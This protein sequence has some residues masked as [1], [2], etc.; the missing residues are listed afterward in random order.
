MKDLTIIILGNKKVDIN[1][2]VE[3]IY[4][5][6]FNIQKDVEKSQGRNIVFIKPEDKLSEYYFNEILEKAQGTYDCCF[7]NYKMEYDYKN[8]LKINTNESELKERKPYYGDY[9]WSFMFNKEKLLKVLQ[10]DNSVEFNQEVDKLF[11]RT[12]A[13]KKVIY[14]HNPKSERIVYKTQYTDIKKEEYYKNII[15]IGEGANGTFNGYISW[16]KNIGRC[17]GNIYD[18]TILY[19]KISEVTFKAFSKYFKCVQRSNNVNYICDRLLVTYSTYFYPQNIIY[20]DQNYMFIHGNMSDYSNSRRYYD[21]IYTHYIAVS[22]IAAKKA[23][24]YFPTKNI[25]H[26]INPF[27]LDEEL[28]KPHLKLTSALRFSHVK[29]PERIEIFAKVL[30]ELNIPYTW[31]VFTDSKENTN[32]NGVIYRKRTPN[33]LPYIKDSDYF[34][35]LSDSE[36]MPYCILEALAVNT[37]VIVTP[38]EAYEEIGVKNKENGY[39]IPFDYFK[40]EYKEE[41]IKVV[42]EIYREKD[43]EVN[44]TIDEK[45]WDGYNNIFVK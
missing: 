30:D 4:S 13:I 1:K 32:I 33:P 34:V 38:L 14:F 27:K 17:F 25:E 31:N 39:I 24:G 26:I 10:I 29:R 6:G 28:V 41:L 9:L 16:I 21:D 37:K 23:E 15:Y 8:T 35:L 42:K 18:I 7:I 43:R 36:A 5:N 20:L 12:T 45:L 40:E 2:D 3:I 22:K 44:N 19:D 11:T